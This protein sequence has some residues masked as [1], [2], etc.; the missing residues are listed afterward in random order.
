MKKV[1]VLDEWALANGI[2]GELAR[3][4]T[5]VFRHSTMRATGN[6]RGWLSF[7]KLRLDPRAQR[8]IRECARAV[9]GFVEEEFPRTWR[10]FEE[11]R[12]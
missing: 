2:A 3:G 11:A 6:L 7:L 1:S 8:E 5:S 4:F 9:A 10:L 12:A